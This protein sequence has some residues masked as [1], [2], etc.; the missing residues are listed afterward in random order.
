MCISVPLLVTFLPPLFPGM[1]KQLWRPPGGAGEEVAS[2]AQLSKKKGGVRRDEG[3]LRNAEERARTLFRL[4]ANCGRSFLFGPSPVLALTRSARPA[5]A[6]A[7]SPRPSARVPRARRGRGRWRGTPGAETRAGR[8]WENSPKV[9]RSSGRGWG[10]S[11]WWRRVLCRPRRGFL[12][13]ASFLF[14]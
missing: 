14:P 8:R 10:G 3:R 2:S 9:A 1:E 6:A 7:S 5:A 11:F 13:R 12:E 4:A